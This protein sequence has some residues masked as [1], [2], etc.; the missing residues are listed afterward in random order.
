MEKKEKLYEGKA[1]ILYTTDSE[2]LLVQYFKDDT[3]AFDGV[4]KEILEDKGVINCAISTVIFEY[5][6]KHGVRTHF[7]ERLS[8]R[9][10]LVKK[11]EIIPVEVV[12]RNVAA[13]SFCRRYG[14]KEGTPLKSKTTTGCSSNSHLSSIHK[15][16][17]NSF[18]PLNNSQRVL[19]VRDLPNLLG[20][21]RK[22]NLL[23]LSK[24]RIYLVLST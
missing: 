7:V 24:F 21:E 20:R 1:K 2:N 12:V 5:L 9:E 19:T 22:V 13:G 3:T 16:L 10:M 15:P 18:S 17:N 23:V 6:E 14:A 11:C 4:K 8:P